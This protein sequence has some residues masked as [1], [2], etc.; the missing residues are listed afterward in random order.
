[1]PR[2]KQLEVILIG[3]V[4]DELKPIFNWGKSFR[5][6]IEDFSATQI[7]VRINKKIKLV[8]E[9]KNPS[10]DLVP[11]NQCLLKG[12]HLVAS[13]ITLKNGNSNIFESSKERLKK[14]QKEIEKEEDP[15]KIKDLMLQSELIKSQAYGLRGNRFVPMQNKIK[16]IYADINLLDVETLGDKIDIVKV[17]WDRFEKK[18]SNRTQDYKEL[19]LEYSARLESQQ[20][21]FYKIITKQQD[22]IEELQQKLV[23]QPIAYG[24]RVTQIISDSVINKIEGDYMSSPD[25]REEISKLKEHLVKRKKGEIKE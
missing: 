1:M 14:I 16:N 13:T 24:N 6:K 22:T 8:M 23:L 18:L 2:Y 21:M 17:L 19:E 20:E 4:A 9:T 15:K 25:L 12:N 5:L 11:L 7:E 10:G 3:Q